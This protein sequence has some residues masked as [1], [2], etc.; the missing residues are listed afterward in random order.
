MIDTTNK[1][2]A[3]AAARFNLGLIYACGREVLRDFDLISPLQEGKLRLGKSD[4]A[5]PDC[6]G[7]AACSATGSHSGAGAGRT[8]NCPRASIGRGRVTGYHYENSLVHVPPP[9]SRR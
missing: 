1:E 9:A 3:P 5:T 6:R 8:T 4:S 2:L 7:C